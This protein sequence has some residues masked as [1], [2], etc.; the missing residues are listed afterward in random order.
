M[1]SPVAADVV[2]GAAA[3]ALAPPLASVTSPPPLHAPD[4]SRERTAGGGGRALRER[5]RTEGG[6]E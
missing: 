4:K 2:V 3:D 1:A 6:G 5:L